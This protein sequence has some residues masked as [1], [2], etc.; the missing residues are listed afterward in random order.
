VK[1]RCSF[2]R[3][4]PS[5]CVEASAV[6]VAT[7]RAGRRFPQSSRAATGRHID[8]R[9]RRTLWPRDWGTAKP[10]KWAAYRQLGWQGPLAC[11]RRGLDPFTALGIEARTVRGAAAATRN[12][13]CMPKARPRRE[14][15]CV[16]T[17]LHDAWKRLHRAA[18]PVVLTDARR[19]ATSGAPRQA[20]VFVKDDCPRLRVSAVESVAAAG[21]GGRSLRWSAAARDDARHPAWA[22][23]A[24]IEPAKVRA[25]DHHPESRYSAW[26]CRSAV[27]RR[28]ARRRARGQTQWQRQ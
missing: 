12:F 3:S 18:Q 20:G 28:A 1:A 6:A 8:A 9:S 15:A 7:E 24:G 5:P 2:V 23:R 11:S 10:K 22:A 14:I 17:R 21:Y 27:C 4:W 13:R 19:S 16:P 25:T 26:A